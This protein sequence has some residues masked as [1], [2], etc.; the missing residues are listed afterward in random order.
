MRKLT[1]SLAAVA[2]SVGLLGGCGGTSQTTAV[3]KVCT[4]RTDLHNAIDTVKT[5]LKNL[6]FGKAKDELPN[7]KKAFDNL[8]QS[9][10]DLKGEEAK[11][12]QPQ[13]DSLKTNID[14]LTNVSSLSELQSSLST[15]SPQIQSIYTD[16]TNTL[17]CS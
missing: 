4:D 14:N 7:V 5:D 6:N 13:I 10:K 9:A 12:L 11:K 1:K 2:I 17:K 16:I 3:E 15:I 8:V